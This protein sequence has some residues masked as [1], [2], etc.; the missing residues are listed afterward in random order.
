MQSKLPR[1]TRV[2]VSGG[3]RA[4]KVGACPSV[5][6][7]P[8]RKV[9]QPQRGLLGSSRLP[10]ATP[11]Q[12]TPKLGS[13]TPDELMLTASSSMLKSTNDTH[14]QSVGQKNNE[15]NLLI[16]REKSALEAL[17]SQITSCSALMGESFKKGQLDLVGNPQLTSQSKKPFLSLILYCKVVYMFSYQFT[18]QVII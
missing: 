3:E 11:D 12:S 18:L 6:K 2:L 10:N 9:T 13:S 15:A 5:A 16:D 1:A 4:T 8:E 17:S 14:A 7:D